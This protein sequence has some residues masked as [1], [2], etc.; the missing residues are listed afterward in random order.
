MGFRCEWELPV[1]SSPDML[2]LTSHGRK[3]AIDLAKGAGAQSIPKGTPG[4][5]E[6]WRRWIRLQPAHVCDDQ[7]YQR[8]VPGFGFY[9]HTW[10]RAAEL[11]A[12]LLSEPCLTQG[13]DQGKGQAQLHQWPT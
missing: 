1:A 10:G 7:S 6:G 12:A 4:H 13:P 5:Q 8:H 2:D 9:P 3:A 11:A